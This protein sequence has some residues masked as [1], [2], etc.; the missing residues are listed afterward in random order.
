METVVLIFFVLFGMC[1]TCGL[2]FFMPIVGNVVAI[3]F[4]AVMGEQQYAKVKGIESLCE[5]KDPHDASA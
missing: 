3:V 5:Q 1:C 2:S 4:Q